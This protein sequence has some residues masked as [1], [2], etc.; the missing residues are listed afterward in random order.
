MKDK[1]KAMLVLASIFGN[2]IHADEIREEGVTNGDVIQATSFAECQ[3]L[4]D[5]AE[6][7]WK[8]DHPD[9]TFISSHGDCYQGSWGA[10]YTVSRVI[11]YSVP[12]AASPTT[13]K[14]DG[15]AKR[16]PEEEKLA[17]AAY[18]AKRELEALAILQKE[19]KR[20]QQP[21]AK[22]YCGCAKFWP[23]AQP[24]KSSG[25]LQ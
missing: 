11:R 6:E 15:A 13:P 20:C 4:Q 23:P 9:Y 2:T 3:K 18:Q 5:E 8:R 12:D 16:R 10:P 14:D 24:G 22:Y 19:R 1:I 7:K 21:Q 25:C 17:L